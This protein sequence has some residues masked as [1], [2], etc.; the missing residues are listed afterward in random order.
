MLHPWGTWQGVFDE[1]A[2]SDYGPPGRCILSQQFYETDRRAASC[3]ATTCRSRAVRAGAR[4]RA[5]ALWQVA[6][7]GRGASRGLSQARCIASVSAICAKD[8]PEERKQRH[9]RS[10]T[11]W[12]TATAFRR[13][14]S[15]TGSARI[16]RRMLAH[17][18]ARGREVMRAAGATDIGSC[19]SDLAW[20]VGTC[21]APRAWAP[22]RQPRW[23]TNG[24]AAMTCE[25]VHRR[26]Q[27]LRDL[28]RRESHH[29]HPGGRA[30][31]RRSDEEAA[32]QPVRLRPGYDTLDLD[33]LGSPAN[34][35]A[36]TDSKCGAGSHHSR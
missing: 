23:S 31:H 25:S 7:L 29:D 20:Q 26:W 10:G 6:A 19:W 13:R 5:S 8:L 12:M 9:A 32:G 30:V 35:V 14:R 22:T 16:S 17:G 15:T 36:S 24:A 1:P 18:L 11:C 34:R 2:D 3:A 4:R 21:S 27:R 28:W 33:C